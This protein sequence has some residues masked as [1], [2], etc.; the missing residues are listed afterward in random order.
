M[1]KIISFLLAATL[2]PT[3]TFANG[4]FPLAANDHTSGTIVSNDTLVISKPY[5]SKTFVSIYIQG[6]CANGANINVVVLDKN[7]KIV[8][9]NIGN[10]CNLKLDFTTKKTGLYYIGMSAQNQEAI[11]FAINFSDSPSVIKKPVET[12]S[13]EGDE[14]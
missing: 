9:K 8:S 10:G 12:G 7:Q 3:I 5:D 1:K 6:E 11:K 4:V 13:L 14:P 2:I